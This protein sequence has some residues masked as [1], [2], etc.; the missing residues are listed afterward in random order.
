ME[1]VKI[2]S[3]K[4]KR[5][6]DWVKKPIGPLSRLHA[7][8]K[9]LRSRGLNTVCESARCPNISECFAKPTATFMILGDTCTRECGFCGVHSGKP[10]P[11]DAQEPEN[12]ALTTAELGLKHV[13]ITSVTRDDLPDFGAGQFALTI[14]AI[15]DTISDILIELLVPDF[16]GDSSALETVLEAGPNI[17]NHNLETV[18]ELYGRVRAGADYNRSL[19]VIQNATEA[20]ALTK[21]GIMLGFGETPAQVRS[22]L[23]DLSGVGCRIVTIGQYLRP[24][25]ESLEV[26]EYIEP[27]VFSEYEGFAREAGIDFVYSGP[28]VRS[29]YNAEEIWKT[30][31][32]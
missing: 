8:K 26:V 28:L 1:G 15:R 29:S 32:E 12:I 24:T 11:V 27:E 19:K 14:R 16:N 21:S 18:P 13:V 6:P 17:L 7:M 2:D 10:A 25:K 5:L 4:V 9:V 22:L 31:T 3:G 23:R 20:G 30:F